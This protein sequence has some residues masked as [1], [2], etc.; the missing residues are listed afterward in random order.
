MKTSLVKR[1]RAS[2]LEIAQEEFEFGLP[3]EKETM[4]AA[5]T[6]TQSNMDGFRTLN[7]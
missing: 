3:H 1:I 7:F 2:D 5:S 4:R 6:S